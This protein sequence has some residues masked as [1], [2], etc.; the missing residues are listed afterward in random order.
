MMKIQ[1]VSVLDVQWG[2]GSKISEEISVW[3]MENMFLLLATLVCTGFLKGYQCVVCPLEVGLVPGGGGLKSNPR[4]KPRQHPNVL[5]ITKLQKL[6]SWK[7]WNHA[8][9]SIRD[10]YTH[11]KHSWPTLLRRTKV[12]CSRWGRRGGRQIGGV[13]NWKKVEKEEERLY[14]ISHF[15]QCM[16]LVAFQLYKIN[17]SAGIVND[18][19]AI[20]KHS[21]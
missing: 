15:V 19:P 8:L 13:F 1:T 11:L 6:Q 3:K 5:A 18:R 16:G 7:E 12:L 20:K 2:V 14:H 21:A 4:A 9:S 17:C 10:S